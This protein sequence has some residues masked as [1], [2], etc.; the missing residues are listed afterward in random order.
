MELRL[1]SPGSWR[2]FQRGND[3]TGCWRVPDFRSSMPEMKKM[4]EIEASQKSTQGLSLYA[5]KGLIG[6]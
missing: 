4:G 3:K 5:P 6:E 2:R 1:E